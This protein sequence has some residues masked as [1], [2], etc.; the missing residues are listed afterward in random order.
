MTDEEVA[1]Y[2]FNRL[3]SIVESNPIKGINFYQSQISDIGVAVFLEYYFQNIIGIEVT[4]GVYTDFDDDSNNFENI[5]TKTFCFFDVHLANLEG[6]IFMAYRLSK[7][8]HHE[9]SNSKI[10]K[11]NLVKENILS[12]NTYIFHVNFDEQIDSFVA[13]VGIAKN[14]V[15]N[16]P[17]SPYI[18]PSH[19][20]LRGITY[21]NQGDIS[22]VE[23][24]GYLLNQQGVKS[25]EKEQQIE[26]ALSY[27]R[28]AVDLQYEA[29]KIN[30]FLTLWQSERYSEAAEWLLEQNQYKP[31]NFYCLWNEAMLRFWGNEI[32]HN[33]IPKS[34]CLD[35]LYKIL[36][37]Y[38]E[39][40]ATDCEISQMAYRFIIQQQIYNPLNSI[41]KEY[42]SKS[43]CDQE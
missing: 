22:D 8:L 28:E 16:F 40:S 36:S 15:D 32:K 23:S 14:V 6:D 31:Y 35:T 38:Y 26:L 19:K 27:F 5:P 1:Y 13:I 30:G 3:N 25:M 12:E 9:V 43:N 2:Y 37:S 17:N 33:P 29:A 42:E 11:T 10:A 7:T 21:F 39:S 20:K 34:D 4:V 18:H 24:E 41:I